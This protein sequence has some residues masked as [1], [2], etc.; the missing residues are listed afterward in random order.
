MSNS[1]ASEIKNQLK[2]SNDLKEDN[3]SVL[4]DNPKS[5]IAYQLYNR[6]MIKFGDFILKS[7]QKSSVYFDLRQLTSEPQFLKQA[8]QKGY[9]YSGGSHNDKFD[10]VCGVPTA[11]IS[12]ATVFSLE[13]DLPNIWVRKESKN[14]GLKRQIEGK[15]KPGQ[16]VLLLDDVITS[17][18][19]LR[20]TITILEN[21]GLIVAEC[22]V[23]IDRRQP[24]DQSS[25]LSKNKNS[26][27]NLESKIPLKCYLTMKE[28]FTTL[29]NYGVDVPQHL[30]ED[31]N[32]RF[33]FENRLKIA[34]NQITHHIL[35]VMK[36]KQSNLIVSADVTTM[37]DL[38]HLIHQV[39]RNA[40]IIKTHIDQITDFNYQ[41][42][43]PQLKSLK[44]ELNFLI[45]ED[46]KFSDIGNTVKNQ[47]LHGCYQIH[48][49]ADLV[50]AHTLMGPGTLLALEEAIM[51][52]KQSISSN[53]MRGIIPVIQAS[54][55]D[56]LLNNDHYREKSLKMVSQ[57]SVVAG[58]VCQER[59][60]DNS[61]LHMT[62]GVK[63]FEQGDQL[64]QR[65]RTPEIAIV[66]QG[67]DMIIVGRGIYQSKDP[68]E[69]AKRYQSVGF[70]ALI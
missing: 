36:D 14:Y 27:N 44:K 53:E 26:K 43:I 4:D 66:E 50:T 69:E 35:T 32:N 52:N 23:L 28:I 13:F 46:R 22:R 45:M 39:G 19:S 38:L 17:G 58:I 8:I 18:T 48:Q 12:L 47:Y 7:G 41:Y 57:S 33:S 9:S 25:Y 40:V 3:T 2:K 70:N 30:L 29:S 49:W 10:L 24:K 63:L 5:H 42:L 68:K 20:E 34:R 65:Y 64:G 6:G 16:R 15:F 21:S 31:H 51:E 1:I 55:Q 11:G 61:F 59:L 67:C 37:D 62:P 54:S 60:L 56:N